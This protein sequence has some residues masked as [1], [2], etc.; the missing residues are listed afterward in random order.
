MDTTTQFTPW[1]SLAGGALIG[2]SAVLLMAFHG[3]IAGLTGL[4]RGVVPP[5]ATD[6]QWRAAFLAGSAVAPLILLA[7]G[8]EIPFAVP[9]SPTA[10]VVGG[11]IV[12]VGVTF[13]NGC[14]S[15]HG[16]CGISRLSP[17]SIV[18][19]VSF[20]I[21]AALTVYVTRHLIGG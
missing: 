12:G 20:M 7:S 6:W 9:V 4:V 8:S 13:G 18:A 11:F 21:T 5:L 14:P 19:V 10:L 3:R 16:V 15:G 17:R 2:L 1:L